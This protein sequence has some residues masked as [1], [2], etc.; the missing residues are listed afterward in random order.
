MAKPE[1][2][3]GVHSVESLLELEPERILTLLP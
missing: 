1:Y 3:Y 2:Y